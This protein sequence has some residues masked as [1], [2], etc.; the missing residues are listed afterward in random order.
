M[1][2]MGALYPWSLDRFDK[3]SFVT[4]KRESIKLSVLGFN[5]VALGAIVHTDCV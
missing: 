2:P 5:V 4:A 1:A 3:G